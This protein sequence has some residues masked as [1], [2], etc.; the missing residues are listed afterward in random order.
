MLGAT[1]WHAL[2]QSNKPFKIIVLISGGIW[3]STT[4]YRCIRFVFYTTVMTIEKEA[5]NWESSRIAVHCDKP[6]RIYPGSYF[7]IFLPGKLL[8]YNLLVSYPMSAM[9]YAPEQKPIQ[10]LTFLVSH[11]SRPLQS[12]R[13]KKG[14]NLLLDGPYGQDLELE[15]YETVLLAAHGT[16]ILGVLSFALYLCQRR[17]IRR[18]LR[19]IN[20]FWSLE[21]NSQDKWVDKKLRKLQKMDP[22][23]VCSPS[24][25]LF[26]FV[27]LT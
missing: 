27:M 6:V 15:Y 8:H 21:Q 5:G 13:F 26:T 3:V 2:S 23:N 4:A 16:G 24:S 17:G 12:L 25:L 9:W 10:D 7:Y 11:N 22:N 1:T 14:E 20:I 18:S 19:R